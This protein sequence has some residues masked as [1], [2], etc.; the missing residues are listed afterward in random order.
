MGRKLLLSQF[1]TIRHTSTPGMV[2]TMKKELDEEKARMQTETDQL[3]D[4]LTKELAD[5]IMRERQAVEEAQAM[6]EFVE[7]REDA[8]RK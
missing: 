3:R 8:A 4:G 5:S 2:E 6:K 1:L 7:V